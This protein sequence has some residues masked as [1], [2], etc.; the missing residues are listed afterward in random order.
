MQ[1]R[2]PKPTH[3][4]KRKPKPEGFDDPGHLAKIRLCPCCICG[5]VPAD[6]HHLLSTEER[7]KRGLRVDALCI[8]LCRRHHDELHFKS[9]NEEA[10]LAE[11][12]VDGRGLARALYSIRRKTIQHYQAVVFAHYQRAVLKRRF[13][14]VPSTERDET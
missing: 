14:A 5:M 3:D 7:R 10:Y 13:A 8:P 2:I 4:F 11:N 12:G 9:G 6:P 1:A